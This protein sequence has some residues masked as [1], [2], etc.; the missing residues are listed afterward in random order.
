VSKYLILNHSLKA[1]NCL[2]ALSSWYSKTWVHYKKGR[3]NYFFT[4]RGEPGNTVL[5]DMENRLAMNVSH[6]PFTE[7]LTQ[8][9]IFCDHILLHRK[10][11]HLAYLLESYI[12]FTLPLLLKVS[13]DIITLKIKSTLLFAPHNLQDLSLY[14]GAV[15]KSLSPIYRAVSDN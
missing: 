1:S 12:R 8:R 3:W 2:T 13:V 4:C 14:V 9:I 7:N 6:I 15:K 11:W 5:T 10:N